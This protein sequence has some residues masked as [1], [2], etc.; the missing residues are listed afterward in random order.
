MSQ[1][2]PGVPAY[3]IPEVKVHVM[4]RKWLY[5]AI[6]G[7]MMVP[8]IIAMILC[9]SKFGA[10]VKLGVD[11]T[12]GSLLQV[13]FEQNV[14]VQQ[15]RDA[16]HHVRLSTYDDTGNVVS[17]DTEK[18]EGEIQEVVETAARSEAATGSADAGS[19]LI[20]RTKE[21]N[22]YQIAELKADLQGPE[23]KLGKFTPERVESV[24]PK[25]GAELMRN[26]LYALAAGIVMIL[27]YIA[28]RYQFDFAVCAI[29]AMVHDVI[30]MV[31]TFAIFSLT[32]GA[33]ADGLFITALL[34][35]MGF[36]V[37]DTIVIFDRFRENLRYAQKG[38]H[39]SDI[40]DR[41]INQ[42]F[43]RSIYTSVTVLLALLPL[44]LF[45]GSSIFF[46]TL[47]M[48]IG[49][50]SGTYSS[51]FNAA[52]LL[53]IWRDGLRAAPSGGTGVAA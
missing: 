31:G 16:L 33:E 25:I 44:V 29:A 38:D 45:G 46:F 2:Q 4:A 35:V 20:L 50:V 13:R 15:F 3:T 47:A 37:H 24:G 14:E 23:L 43:L 18:V 22:K 53:V 7:L 51:I 10:P 9:F 49:I 48:V 21:L 5:F 28:F 34:T 19:T 26:A 52:P 32:L 40:A 42:T 11:F 1:E 30:V 12:G 8:G 36:S 6:S 17:R 39:F 41:S 27:A